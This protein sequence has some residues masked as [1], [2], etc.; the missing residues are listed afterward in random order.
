MY[1]LQTCFSHSVD[2]LSFPVKHKISCEFSFWVMRCS[3]IDCGHDCTTLNILKTIKPNALK[4]CAL[5]HV[6][7]ISLLLKNETMSKRNG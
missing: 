2:V 5:W 3:R 1:D 4:I 7:Y 6:Y